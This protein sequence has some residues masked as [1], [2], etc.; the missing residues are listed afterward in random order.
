MNIKEKLFQHSN[1]L[2]Q[3]FYIV[4]L[5]RKKDSLVSAI[6]SRYPPV[7]FP[8][9]QIQDDMIVNVNIFI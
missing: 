4:G 5:S 3:N 7:D 6:L 2:I 8:Y 1:N 9:I